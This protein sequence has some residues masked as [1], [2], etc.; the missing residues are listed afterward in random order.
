MKS[1]SVQSIMLQV[2]LALIPAIG[3]HVILFGWGI[4]VQI[5]LA[6]AFALIFEGLALWLRQR[7]IR[8]F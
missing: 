1:L 8:V 6:M 5:L 2:L 4:L 7:P 3:V